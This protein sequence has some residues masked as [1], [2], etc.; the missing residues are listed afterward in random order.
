MS[1]IFWREVKFVP[2]GASHWSALAAIA[3]LAVLAVGW[4]RRIRSS[5]AAPSWSRLF[6]VALLLV[7]VPFQ[8]Y[9]MIPPHWSLAKSLPFELCDLAWM[10]AAYAL[11]A[12]KIWAFGLLYYWGLTLTPQALVTPQLDFDFPHLQY[13]MFWSSHGL[14]VLAALFLTWGLG[15]YPTWRLYRQTVLVT[16]AWGAAMLV[17][18]GLTGTNYL[19]A[20]HKPEVRS[21]L[22]LF[23]PWPVY[24]FVE[25]AAGATVWALLTAPWYW[26]ARGR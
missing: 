23:G 15:Y 17:F 4:G 13:L 16:L 14:T 5:P 25:A 26:A 1:G 10:A 19:F 6:A 3:V 2:Y 11:W 18:N 7:D 12:R 24:L 22:D 8:I 21:L 9:S 20:S